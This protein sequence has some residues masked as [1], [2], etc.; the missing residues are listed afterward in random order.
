MTGKKIAILGG[1][2]GAH[3]MAADFILRGHQVNLY[4]MPGFRQNMETVFESKKIRIRGEL[5]ATVEL[6]LV[7]DD[8]AAAIDG[9]RYICVVTP[10]F[11]HQDYAKLLQGKVGKEQIIVSFPGAFA[12]LEF[13]KAFANDAERPVCVDVSN[14]PYITRLTTPGCVTLFGYNQKMNVAFLPAEA[15]PALFH[16]L[17]DDIFPFE[18]ILSDVLECGLS[19]LNPSWHTGPCLFNVSNIERPDV[20]FF[21][22]EHGWTPSACKVNLAL[23]NE[24][25]AVGKALGYSMRP[26]E[27]GAELPDNYTWQN[28]YAAG[29]GNIG[30]TPVCG[31][32]DILSRYLTEDTAFGLV[33]WAALGALCHVPMPLT[34]AAIDLYCVIHETDWRVRGNHLDRMGL[35][36]LSKE[37]VLAYVKTGRK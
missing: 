15:G 10:A 34:N 16:E 36:G 37:Q 26:M 6:N 23:D 18:R 24:R 19:I 11:A 20:N 4:E 22:Y 14:L 28:L 12:A 7:T 30:L 31:P 27:E 35:A 2:N 32:N 17:R 3:A 25:K 9:V 1:G 21:L 8:I 13:Y 33:P 29:H 5:N